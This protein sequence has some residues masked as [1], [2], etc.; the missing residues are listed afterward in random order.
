[1]KVTWKNKKIFFIDY[2]KAFDKVNHEKLK[3]VWMG[4]MCKT[5]LGSIE[6][7][8]AVVR[9]DKW[10]SEGIQIRRGTRPGCAITVSHLS[11]S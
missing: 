9:R 8:T 6:G 2:E 10:N 5:L 7:Q 1:M 4:K 3:L 11:C